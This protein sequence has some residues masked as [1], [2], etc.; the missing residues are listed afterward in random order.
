MSHFNKTITIYIMITFFLFIFNYIYGLF[1]H[2]VSSKSMSNM[3]L[4]S[5][6]LGVLFFS[7]IKIILPKINLQIKYRLFYNIHNS[8]VALLVNGLML[9]GI[10][11]IAGGSSYL[12]S[13]FFYIGCFLLIISIIMFI[14]MLH[15]LKRAYTVSSSTF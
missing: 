4:V 11:E 9:T 8:S 15:S 13:W 1:G 7:L 14:S 3:Y 2:G 5:L 10:I 12:I 6:F